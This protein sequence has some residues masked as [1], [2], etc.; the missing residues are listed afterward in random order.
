MDSY[1]VEISPHALKQLELRLSITKCKIMKIYLLS[2]LKIP[3][4]K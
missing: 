3:R 4:H 2:L 1:K